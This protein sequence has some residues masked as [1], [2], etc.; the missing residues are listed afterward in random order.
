MGD[1]IQ[2]TEEALKGEEPLMGISEMQEEL[3][4]LERE[5]HD[6]EISLRSITPIVTVNLEVQNVSIIFVKLF[7]V[8]LAD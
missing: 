2:T 8:R 5:T 7:C 1:G 4:R 3:L 6:N